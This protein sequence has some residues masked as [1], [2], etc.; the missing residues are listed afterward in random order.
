MLGTLVDLIDT[1]KSS[2]RSDSIISTNSVA[3][4]TRAS[5]RK[6]LERVQVLGQRAEL[7][8]IRIGTPGRGCARS[9]TSATFSRPLMLPGLRRMQ[10]APASIALSASV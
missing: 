1:L 3:A 10:C 5:T 2:K 4:V 8:P 7:T 6:Q 9:A